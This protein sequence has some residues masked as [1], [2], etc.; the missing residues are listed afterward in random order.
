MRPEKNDIIECGDELVYMIIS[1]MNRSFW[2]NRTDFL[3]D[4]VDD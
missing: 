3:A 4:A 2:S 1:E